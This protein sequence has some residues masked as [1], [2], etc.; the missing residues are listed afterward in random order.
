M[1]SL[2]TKAQITIFRYPSPILYKYCNNPLILSEVC[3]RNVQVDYIF[4][5]GKISISDTNHLHINLFPTQ[6]SC[7][8]TIFEPKN[9][10]NQFVMQMKCRIVE[11]PPPALEIRPRNMRYRIDTLYLKVG[12]TLSMR[13]IAD[14]EFELL[15]P[16]ECH[17]K[18]QKVS[19][20]SGKKEMLSLTPY[21]KNEALIWVV[22]QAW[23]TL[24]EQNMTL[25]ISNIERINSKG[26]KRIIPKTAYFQPNTNIIL[27]FLPH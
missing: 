9:N 6:D 20:K 11:P 19:I 23:K 15:M 22:P 4:E 18:P 3:D 26:E 12:D 25:S 24:P 17:Y 2:S 21:W 7:F 27:H 10:V 13:F 8:L 14:P 5:G 16:D 1:L